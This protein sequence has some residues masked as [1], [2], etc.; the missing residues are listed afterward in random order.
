MRNA[1]SPRKIDDM[2]GWFSP[3]ESDSR[4][5]G[6]NPNNGSLGADEVCLAS[7]LL[8][9][10]DHMRK[11]SVVVLTDRGAARNIFIGLALKFF[12]G[13]CRPPLQRVTSLSNG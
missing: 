10:E 13:S 11:T 8:N 1:L 6:A 7:S 9:G 4:V 12:S 5:V 2:N 3:L